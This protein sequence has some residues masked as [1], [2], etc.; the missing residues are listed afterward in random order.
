MEEYVEILRNNN[1]TERN[2]GS[3][4]GEDPILAKQNLESLGITPEERSTLLTQQSKEYAEYRAMRDEGNTPSRQKFDD[5]RTWIEAIDPA[6]ADQVTGVALQSY[7]EK[8]NGSEALDFVEQIA[9]DYLA[10]GAG[11]ELLIPLIEGSAK[12]RAF[13]KEKARALATKI[14]DADLRSEMLQK[15]N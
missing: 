12:G 5:Y 8:S 1:L 10:S 11:D 6:A 2:F 7:L 15:L 4:I 13:P 9:T 3:E 14:T